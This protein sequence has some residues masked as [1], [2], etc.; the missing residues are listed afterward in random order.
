MQ[1]A[2]EHEATTIRLLL[3]GGGHRSTVGS[4]GAIAYLVHV[5]RWRS[6]DEVVSVSGGS[7]ANAALASATDDDPWTV[8][9]ATIKRIDRDQGRLWATPRRAALLAFFAL[10]YTL[11]VVAV[12]V[13]VGVGPDIPPVVSVLVG[14]LVFPI[15]FRLGGLAASMLVQDF[16]AV[17]SGN[18]T[19]KLTDDAGLARMHVFCTSGLS[20]AT[21]YLLWTGR[22]DENTVAPSW[23]AEL[24]APYTVVEAA[25]ASVSLPFLGRVRSPKDSVN[26]DVLRGGELLVDGGVSGIFGEQVSTSF[27]RTPADTDR[28]DDVQIL[29]IDGGRH[30]TSPSPIM[31]ALGRYSALAILFRWLKASLEATY[32]NDLVDIGPDSLV[33]LSE[34]DELVAVDE[35][36]ADT[37]GV[38]GLP[39]SLALRLG[40]TPPP[41]RDALVKDRL[42]QLRTRVA[43]T[44]LMNL[45]E[46][47]IAEAL[48]AGFVGT[49]ILL[50]PGSSASAVAEAL[51]SVEEKLGLANRL[52]SVWEDLGKVHREDAA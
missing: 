16:I 26:P 43:Q 18:S 28:S 51:V 22:R 44:S 33:R 45:N 48:V 3:S 40:G 29:A 23:G 50:D 6:V 30:V 10:A 20:S 15:S 14:V 8:L 38:G 24:Q 5:N 47:R 21:P 49:M 34:A 19:R 39:A 35:T 4:L 27:R 42:G 41:V 17:V 25:L 52:S 1:P 2:Q 32:V 7:I 31:R 13:A 9:S 46:Q 37:D 12:L 11:I 36:E